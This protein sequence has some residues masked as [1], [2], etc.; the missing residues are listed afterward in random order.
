MKT[1]IFMNSYQKQEDK[2]TYNFLSLLE[3]LNDKKLLEWLT[4]INLLEKPIV[5]IETIYSGGFTNPD[6]SFKLRKSD[7]NLTNIYFENKTY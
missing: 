7:G 4:G 1:N 6:G 5:N 3:L 2:L